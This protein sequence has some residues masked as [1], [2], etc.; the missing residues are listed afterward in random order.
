[1]IESLHIK[2]FGPIQEVVL[3]D[4]R[5]LTI[6][7]GPSGSGKS[8]AL[9]LLA[10]FRWLYKRASIKGYLKASGV[11]KSGKDIRFRTLLKTSG[12]EE[13]LKPNSEIRYSRDG[14]MIYYA[15]G[16]L[17]KVIVEQPSCEKIAFISDKRSIISDY[18]D[19]KVERR[20]GGYYLQDTIDNFMIAKDSISAMNLPFL[21]VTFKVEKVNNETQYRFYGDADERY[22]V[23]M[24]A[25]SSG[26][27][28]VTPL[29]MITEYFSSHFNPV[30]S[31]AES[32]WQYMAETDTLSQFSSVKNV[33]EI[34]NKNVHLLLEEPELNLDPQS[35]IRLV[36]TLIN[37][38]FYTNRSYNMTLAM[39]THSPY[40]LN[41]LNLLI[42]RHQM[43]SNEVKLSFEN[44]SVY[45]IVEGTSFDLKIRGEEMLVDATSMSDPISQIYAEYNALNKKN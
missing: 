3:D 21:N 17:N 34:E 26:M 29:C 22:K 39:A 12:V 40:I 19:H 31:F 9:K 30:K 32:L 18:L 33:G 6:L 25:G 10:I 23:R 37:S 5:P 36:D 43:N 7:I 45:E 15:N 27:Q 20:T 28:T 4:I 11:S 42:R 13:Y 14:A 44:L 16:K 38:C 2:N 8:T 41:Y 24:S 35:Q 1:M